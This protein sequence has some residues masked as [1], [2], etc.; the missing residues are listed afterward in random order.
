MCKY[1]LDS[2]I[3]LTILMFGF[4]VFEARSRRHVCLITRYF[5]VAIILEDTLSLE[6]PG[7]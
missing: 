5:L 4:I 7:A 1:T 6:F 3:N 2:K